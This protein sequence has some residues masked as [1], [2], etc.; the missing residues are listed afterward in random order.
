[1]WSLRY[2]VQRP[3]DRGMGLVQFSGKVVT[4]WGDYVVRIK[5]LLQ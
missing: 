3:A 1:M 5:G 2:P 4:T